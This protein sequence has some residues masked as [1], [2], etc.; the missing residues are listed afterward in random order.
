MGELVND[1]TGNKQHF[2]L[3]LSEYRG[4]VTGYS[5][6]TFFEND[7]YYYSVKRIK[8]IKKDD[9]WIIE[10][11][12][13][14]ANNF[15]EKAAKGVKQTTTFTLNQQDSTWQMSGTW[16]TSQTRVYYSLAGQIQMTAEKDHEKSN[17]FPHLGDL[18][19]Q[20]DVPF[21]TPQKQLLSM[22]KFRVDTKNSPIS[23]PA[24]GLKEKQ[25]S[26]VTY[27]NAIIEKETQTEN[28]I[29]VPTENPLVYDGRNVAVMETI[30]ISTDSISLALYDNGEIDGDTVSVYLGAVPIISKECLKA[31]AIK[32]IINPTLDQNGEIL[33]VLQAENLGKYPPNT[34]LLVVRDGDKMYQVR[35]SADMQNSPAI[36]L[37]RKAP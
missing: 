14:I 4:K 6:T 37:K 15:P 33:L 1:S 34:G 16:K 30:Y 3:A 24:S 10:D 9:S 29:A 23:A 5:Y 8:A 18:K 20:D 35:F 11:D 31:S 22:G 13:M 27:S 7:H 19:L 12:K 17:L 25:I 32:R 26:P 2:E 36:I 28:S 21:Y